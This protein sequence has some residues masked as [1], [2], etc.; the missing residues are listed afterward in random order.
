MKGKK[1]LVLFTLI[2]LLTVGCKNQ[3]EKKEM[4]KEQLAANPQKVALS[5]SGMTCEIGCAK[6]IQSKLNKK[7]G[8][9][10]AAVSFKDSIANIAYDANI[11]SKADLIS[12]VDK[13]ADGKLY[14]ASEN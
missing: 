13:L 12:L 3:S 11:V 9:L 5:I 1:L 14:S 10:E 4:L 6:F 8:V 2:S 7:E